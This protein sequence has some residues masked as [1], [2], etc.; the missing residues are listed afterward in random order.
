M[1]HHRATIP[2]NENINISLVLNVFCGGVCLFLGFLQCCICD[3]LRPVNQPGNE[4]VHISLVLLMFSK[5]CFFHVFSSFVD[6]ICFGS[7]AINKLKNNKILESEKVLI[8][9]F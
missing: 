5:R 4:H 8:C 7:S 3:C 6:V 9:W 2:R 1:E